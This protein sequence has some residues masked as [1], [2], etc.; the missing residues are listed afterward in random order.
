MVYWLVKHSFERIK[1]IP[2]DMNGHASPCHI[3]P[4]TSNAESELIPTPF[5]C[6]MQS[7]SMKE[8]IGE[9]E[10][11]S[12]TGSHYIYIVLCYII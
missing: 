7:F 11:L 4:S 12:E 1:G 10:P 3:M 5:G 6:V 2:G 9:S 8:L